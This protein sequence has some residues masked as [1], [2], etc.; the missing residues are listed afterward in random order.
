MGKNLSVC[1]DFNVVQSLEENKS[2]GA[3]Q[4]LIG[5]DAFN[6]LINDTSLINLPLVGHKFTWFRGDEKSMSRLDKFLLLEM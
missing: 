2:V 1:G 4:Q 5:C 6:R 3:S